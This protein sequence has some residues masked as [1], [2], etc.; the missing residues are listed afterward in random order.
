MTLEL[1]ASLQFCMALHAQVQSRGGKR[2][3]FSTTI[4]T[5]AI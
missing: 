3:I 2:L 4:V 5:V 1:T